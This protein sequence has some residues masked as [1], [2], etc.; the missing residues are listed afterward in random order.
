Q[1]FAYSFLQ[2]PSRDGHP[3]CSA[4]HFPLSGRVQDFHLLERAHGAQTKKTDVY[5]PINTG[6][7][8]LM[9]YKIIILFN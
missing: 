3:C 2:I 5:V 8:T 9:F 1:R 7:D 4:I 6:L